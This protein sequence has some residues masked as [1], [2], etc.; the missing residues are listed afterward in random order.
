MS[1]ESPRVGDEEECREASVVAGNPR[2]SLQGVG[3]GVELPQVTN[4][5]GV[6]ELPQGDETP[7]VTTTGEEKPR[8]DGRGWG[9]DNTPPTTQ[10]TKA[11]GAGGGYDTCMG[12]PRTAP[13]PHPQKGTAEDNCRAGTLTRHTVG[14]DGARPEHGALACREYGLLA[15]TVMVVNLANMGD[16]GSAYGHEAIGRLDG[17]AQ[18]DTEDGDETRK[19]ALP[20]HGIQG[21]SNEGRRTTK[22]LHALNACGRKLG[23]RGGV[24]PTQQ[25]APTARSKRPGEGGHKHGS[26]GP[27]RET[28]SWRRKGSTCPSSAHNPHAGRRGGGDTSR[29]PRASSTCSLRE[30]EWG[31][32]K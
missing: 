27:H 2:G 12:G 23:E 16:P 32:F 21:A 26:A 15:P 22:R 3:G 4:T 6:A 31:G 1:H 30:E 20:A 14:T 9:G 17:Q 28:R 24:P 7:G 8:K 29:R 11:Q 25:H 18:R 13:P 19:S 5:P 10:A